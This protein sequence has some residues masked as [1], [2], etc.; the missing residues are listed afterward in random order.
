MSRFE[1]YKFLAEA[2]SYR[3][4][5]VANSTNA[6]RTSTGGQSAPHRKT[7]SLLRRKIWLE[8]ACLF[9]MDGTLMVAGIVNGYAI[10]RIVGA[11]TITGP[12]AVTAMIG[13]FAK[14]SLLIAFI[15]IACALRGHYH[16][17]NSFWSETRDILLLM[18]LAVLLDGFAHLLLGPEFQ[19]SQSASL[20]LLTGWTVSLL[21]LPLGRRVSRDLLIKAGLWSRRVLIIGSGEPAQ[22]AHAALA[23]EP[24]FGYQV[25]TSMPVDQFDPDNQESRLASLFQ[26]MGGSLKDVLV[27]TMN[28]AK[29]EMVVLAPTAKEFEL[30]EKITRQL[31]RARIKFSIIPPLKG[32][33]VLHVRATAFYNHDLLMLSSEDNLRQPIARII[34]RCF[35]LVVAGGLLLTLSPF[36]LF[37]AALIKKD[38]GAAF[39]GHRRVGRNG[40]MF[41]CLKFRTMIV[42]A[43]DR[44][45][46]VIANDPEKAA[47]WERE[48][49]L[50][51]D[52]RITRIGKFLRDTS[53]DE[54]PQLLN[55]LK[56]EMSLVGLRPVVLD[57]LL[58]YGDDVE[59]YLDAQPGITGLWQV[60][61]RNNVS[62]ERRV[63]LDAWYIRN[64]TLWQDVTILLKTVPAVWL[65]DGAY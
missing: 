40:D 3:N 5:A 42:N 1:T 17:R 57:E 44:L 33:A 12:E 7:E 30:I 34:K 22:S 45:A 63:Q 21:L 26:E 52:P 32:L 13:H 27:E 28:R 51:D 14:S 46:E 43:E 23:S 31:N 2:N 15:L 20:W 24:Y 48:H 8:R 36:F 6:P 61:G 16:N 19:I 47:E 38:G 41:Y 64:W 18:S 53:L 65:R 11:V 39:F 35:D 37:A 29:V 55:V 59:Y 25:E 58:K 56:G 4:G 60:S 10:A 54:L 9:V 62:Y 50:K 49:K